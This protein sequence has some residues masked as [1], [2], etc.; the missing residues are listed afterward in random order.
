MGDGSLVEFASVVDALTAA[1]IQKGVADA[2]RVP[3]DQR[4]AL[5]I[6]INIGDI[7]I[8]ADDISATASMSPHA[9]RP[10]RARRHLRISHRL[11]P[12]QEQGGARLRADGRAPVKNIPEPVVVY[13]VLTEPGPIAKVFRPKRA[14]TPRRRQAAFGAVVLPLLAVQVSQ[15]GY[16]HG[17]APPRRP[18]RSML[19]LS[20]TSRRSL[21]SPSTTSATMRRRNISPTG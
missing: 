18:S 9:S 13:R 10:C 11:R 4:I 8:E 17:S 20:R 7:I 1:A 15:P 21:C 3:A 12:R 6:G 2:R 5:R 19:R 16:S 14:G